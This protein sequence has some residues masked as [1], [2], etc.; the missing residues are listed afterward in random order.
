[1]RGLMSLHLE[2]IPGQ[3]RRLGLTAQKS[4]P[5]NLLTMPQVPSNSLD[6]ISH[7]PV[8]SSDEL[9]PEMSDGASDDWPPSA[10]KSGLSGEASTSKSERGRHAL[11]SSPRPELDVDKSNIPSTSFFS[12]G[13]S[14]APSSSN[15]FKRPFRAMN[16]GAFDEDEIT[17]QWGPFKKP[18]TKT[19]YGQGRGSDNRRG[20]QAVNQGSKMKRFQDP[21]RA[22]RNKPKAQDK[23]SL[24]LLCEPG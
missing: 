3:K 5:G 21:S 1:M 20:S 6:D 24:S 10:K 12:G 15:L 14:S 19:T 17:E 22:G 2:P 18:K 13:P 9:Q 11:G 16:D 8:S 4:W 23:G 7:N